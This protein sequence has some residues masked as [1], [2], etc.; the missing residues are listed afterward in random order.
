MRKMISRG[1][2]PA[3]LFLC[4]VS[5]LAQ[6][7]PLG[8]TTG[9]PD[10]EI[11]MWTDVWRPDIKMFGRWITPLGDI[12]HDGYDDIAVASFADTT[13]IFLGGEEFSHEPIMFLL[14]GGGGI[15]AGDFNRDGRMDLATAIEGPAHHQGEPDPGYHGKLRFFLGKG[16]GAPFDNIPDLTL[17]GEEGESLGFIPNGKRGGIAALDYNG[18]GYSDLLAV[19]YKFDTI[20]TKQ[21]AMYL[22][23]STL[24]SLPVGY[25]QARKDLASTHFADDLMIGDVNGDGLDDVIVQSSYVSPAPSLVYYWDLHLGNALLWTDKL[26]RVLSSEN[27]WAPRKGGLSNLV[28]INADGYDDIFDAQPT[29][30]LGDIQ[31]FLSGSTLP[32]IIVSNDTIP[33]LERLGL[34]APKIICPAGDMNGDGREDVLVG[35]SDLFFR[36][37]TIYQL[38][39]GGPSNKYKTPLGVFGILSDEHHLELGAFKIG[40][41]NGDGCDDVAVLGQPSIQG[42]PPQYRFRIYLGSREMQTAVSMPPAP[43]SLQIDVYPNPVASTQDFLSVSM[44]STDFRTVNLVLS[45]M[46]GRQILQAAVD[47]TGGEQSTNL[48][49]RQLAP[50]IYSLIAIQGETRVS[51]P[52]IIF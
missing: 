9:L 51:Q 15:A 12:N 11:K 39:P 17:R 42:G 27:G 36:E 29:E 22:G 10:Y 23:G 19:V 18:D 30:G 46:L 32:D 5:V 45:D 6:E 50:G 13:F 52:V 20:W 4:S 8:K 40:D 37:G 3:L 2:F 28:D 14:G 31:L 34:E 47:M 33:N 43:Q 21:I 16:S 26:D 1:F 49:I 38:Y 7:Y 25:I 48:P 35:W 24:D 44:N 41:V